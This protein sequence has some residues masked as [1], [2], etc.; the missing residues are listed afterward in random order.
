M[1]KQNR[2]PKFSLLHPFMKSLEGVPR[3]ILLNSPVTGCVA[4]SENE[5]I[6]SVLKAGDCGKT[7]SHSEYRN[8]T[9]PKEQ[10]RS[11]E[12]SNMQRNSRF[13]KTDSCSANSRPTAGRIS[14]CVSTGTESIHAIRAH[15]SS[16]CCFS[17][18][19]PQFWK[20]RRLTAK[21]RTLLYIAPAGTF[22]DGTKLD[23]DG[24]LNLRL[25]AFRV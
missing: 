21:L 2:F 12:L 24:F 6:V 20:R 4:D 9:K 23:F 25:P 11:F 3:C 13:L 16:N 10:S 18:G 19:F 1:M 14:K 5:L 22:G 7:L 8:G 15:A 17:L